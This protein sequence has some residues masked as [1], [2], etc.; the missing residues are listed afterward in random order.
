[1]IFDPSDHPYSKTYHIMS[2]LIIPR[3]IAWISTVSSDGIHNLAPFSFYTGVSSNPPVL[4]VSV[5]RHGDGLRMKDTLKNIRGNGVFAVNSVPVE[6]GEKMVITASD[7]DPDID[8][9]DMAK[10]TPVPCDKITCPRIMESPAVMECRVLNMVEVGEGRPGS[11]TLVL[12]E[13][14]LFHLHKAILD[15][16][17]VNI[18]KLDSL[19]RLN[20]RNYT[21]LSDIFEL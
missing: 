20:N 13:V 12:G 16:D 21:R 6:L 4:A 17:R 10:L 18:R 14:V 8:E 1:M 11:S 7:A 5:G 15:G 19:G 2:S 3:P 9:F